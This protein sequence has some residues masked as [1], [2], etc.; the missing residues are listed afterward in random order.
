MA[1]EQWLEQFQIGLEKEE[2]KM[3]KYSMIST[4]E[5]SMYSG[6]YLT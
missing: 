6:F 1:S 2:N 4:F 5:S 3:R